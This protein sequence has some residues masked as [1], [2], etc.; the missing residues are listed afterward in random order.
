MKQ[1][2]LIVL[3]EYMAL[4]ITL[5]SVAMSPKPKFTPWPANGCILWAASLKK[6]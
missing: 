4:L 1:L 5:F 6:Q 3:P 2:L